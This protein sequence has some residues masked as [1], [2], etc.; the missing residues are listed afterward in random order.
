MFAACLA[1]AIPA[2]GLALAFLM[3]V[4]KY[5]PAGA[6]VSV[7]LC[8]LIAPL[9]LLVARR[10]RRPI[11]PAGDPSA[12]A[13]GQGQSSRGANAAPPKT[14]PALSSAAATAAPASATPTVATTPAATGPGQ[15]D[16]SR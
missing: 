7:A 13:T 2:A 10:T 8:L 12:T 9:L 6:W 14:A 15:N 5:S 11:P 16:P 3:V 4:E 1:L